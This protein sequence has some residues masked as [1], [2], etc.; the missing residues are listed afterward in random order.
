M[1]AVDQLISTL[2][3]AAFDERPAIKAEI[4]AMARASD[5][6]LVREHLD[7][8]KRGELLEIQWEID[9]IL[10]ES[11]PPPIEP[12]EVEEP[13]D[14]T[15]ETEPTTDPESEPTDPNAPLT[16][17]DL[18]MVYDD[19]RGFM[20]HKSKVGDRWFATQ[21][22]PRTGQPQTFELHANELEQIKEQLQGSPYWRIG[23]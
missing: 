6:A 4:L 10:E 3:G 13:S 17:S 11:A 7:T 19:P 2:R 21:V 8:I 14:G 1:D 23:N 18:D 5:G 9:D 16:A 15:D 12:E 22:D 20:L